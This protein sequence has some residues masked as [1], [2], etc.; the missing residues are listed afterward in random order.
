[1]GPKRPVPT[2]RPS[3]AGGDVEHDE[4]EISFQTDDAPEATLPLRV[5]ARPETDLLDAR[6]LIQTLEFTPELLETTPLLDPGQAGDAAPTEP[7]IDRGPSLPSSLGQDYLAALVRDPGTVVVFWELTD[8]TRRRVTGPDDTPV[9][10]ERWQLRLFGPG[11]SRVLAPDIGARGDWW[12]YLSPDTPGIVA[13][14]A[15]IAPDLFVPVLWSRPF[16][17]PSEGPSADTSVRWLKVLPLR[18]PRPAATLIRVLPKLPEL[19]KPFD[20]AL[21]ELTL[22]E[23]SGALEPSPG[24]HTPGPRAAEL[25]TASP[26]VARL[27]L[28]D[29]A[30]PPST[31]V[32][33]PRLATEGQSRQPLEPL[34]AP[35]PPRTRLPRLSAGLALRH[36]FQN[37]YKRLRAFLALEPSDEAR[38][39]AGRSHF[40]AA[41]QRRLPSQMT[42]SGLR[43][44]A[45]IPASPDQVDALNLMRNPLRSPRRNLQRTPQWSPPSLPTPPPLWRTEPVAE[46]PISLELLEKL[47][48]HLSLTTPPE[49]SSDHHGPGPEKE[50]QSP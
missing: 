12:V 23:E 5:A 36:R 43:L 11:I 38:A 13:L 45:Q 24:Q 46:G 39:R 37:A 15:V 9:T 22:Q 34:W 14:G 40:R 31:L 33:T 2:R 4:L 27:P 3:N 26:L 1:M 21:F 18:D 49:G 16:R 29:P 25:T 47:G 28:F 44:E 20:P 32:P 7:Y 50:G 17:T 6:A 30:Q 19:T 10:P 41:I 8:S 35:L 48:G 42:R